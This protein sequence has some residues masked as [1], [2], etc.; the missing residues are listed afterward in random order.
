MSAALV[1]A[2]YNGVDVEFTADGWFNAT[3]VAARHG[4]RPADWLRLPDTERYLDA[5]CRKSKVGKSHFARSARGG[6]KGTAG[7]WLHPK[8]AVRFAQWLDIDFAVW[9]DEQID[10]LLRGKQ[11]WRKL[12]H[13][14][15]S[16]YKVMTQILQLTREEQGKASAPHHFTN[17]ARMVNWALSGVMGPLDRDA[18]SAG[19]LDLLAA[20]EQRNAV[21]IAQGRE[22]AR[23]KVLL[24]QHAADWR[25]HHVQKI[26]A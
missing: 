10:S 22:Y 24:E 8:L 1:L 12:R 19:E 9:C 16:S 2:R 5:L 13:E 21:L 6:A 11:D 20:L 25:L 17:E 14:A 15:A 26:A 18:L 23:R 7:T 4:K 3:A